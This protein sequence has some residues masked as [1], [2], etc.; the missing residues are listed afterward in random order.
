MD[1]LTLISAALCVSRSACLLLKRCWQAVAEWVL[2]RFGLRSVLWSPQQLYK[3]YLSPAHACKVP[4]ATH[5]VAIALGRVPSR[6][7]PPVK[8]QLR[9]P[10]PSIYHGSV[11]SSTHTISSRSVLPR[12]GPNAA[13][14]HCSHPSAM[15][16]FSA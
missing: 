9:L 10:T 7:S 3:C 16:C 13:A 11:W 15:T 4:S 8:P 12:P 5:K 6:I 1:K 2:G 14:H